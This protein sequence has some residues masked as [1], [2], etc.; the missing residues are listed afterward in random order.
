MSI[1]Y[2]FGAL[3]VNELTYIP[4]DGDYI[5]AADNGYKTLEKLNIHPDIVIGDFDS[6]GY[7]PNGENIN[8]LPVE[9]D[10]TDVGFAIKYAFSLGYNE[11][12]IYGALGGL[13]DHTFA[14]L[15]LAVYVSKKGGKAIFAGENIFATA[16]TNNSLKIKN[17]KG[18]ISVFSADEVTRGV[19]LTG[20]KYSLNNADL[21]NDF[22]I[23]VSNEFVNDIAEIKVNDGTAIIICESKI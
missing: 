6:L 22:P 10:D 4:T 2:I 18:R 9:K 8:R 1:C 12:V 14:N 3:D 13:L 15:Q 11:F 19:Y 20:L 5:I 21:T 23:G 16:I 7:V 17:G